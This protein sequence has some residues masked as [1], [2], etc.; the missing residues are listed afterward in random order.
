MKLFVLLAV[1]AAPHFKPSVLIHR[2]GLRVVDGDTFVYRETK[3]RL[4]A[5]TR[6]VDTPETNIPCQRERGIAAKQRFG[7]LLSQGRLMLRARARGPDK[8]GRKLAA[9]LVDGRD[10]GEV[11]ISEGHAMAYDGGKRKDW[12]QIEAKP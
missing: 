4:V 11:L 6:G 9:L 2:E 12:C 5:M 3:Y 8:Y 1:L 10:V 7:Q